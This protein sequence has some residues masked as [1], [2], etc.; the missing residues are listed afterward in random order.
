MRFS[1][2]RSEGC[3]VNGHVDD[4]GYGHDHEHVL[5]HEHEH[6]HVHDHERT[7]S[8]V[9]VDVPVNVLGCFIISG[10]ILVRKRHYT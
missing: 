2:R 4:H 1:A 3:S 5:E 7:R 9:D 10:M 6:V 8:T